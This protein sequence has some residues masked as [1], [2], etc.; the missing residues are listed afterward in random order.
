MKWKP[1]QSH[2]TFLS[3]SPFAPPINHCVKALGHARLVEQLYRPVT[4]SLCFFL[5]PWHFLN[6]SVQTW[7]R[8]K[9]RNDEWSTCSEPP[10][11]EH[12]CMTS[13]AIV[14]GMGKNVIY[15]T[16]SHRAATKVCI[17]MLRV[18]SLT[19]NQLVSSIGRAYIALTSL[20]CLLPSQ[21]AD[22]GPWWAGLELILILHS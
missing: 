10:P 19:D 13:N 18:K 1:A 22:E 11:T 8:F 21:Q 20:L 3:P 9:H 5:W 2:Q 14:H 16:C 17:I 15:S 7:Y 4:L 6:C 12:F